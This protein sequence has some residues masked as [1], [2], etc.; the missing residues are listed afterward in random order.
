[1]KRIILSLVSVL[2]IFNTAHSQIWEY[3]LAEGFSSTVRDKVMTQDGGLVLCGDYCAGSF[4]TEFTYNAFVMKLSA[5]GQVEW[6]NLYFVS[7][8]ENVANGIDE[9]A[10]GELLVSLSR[11]DTTFLRKL[12]SDGNLIWEVMDP[13]HS[14]PR[15]VAVADNNTIYW[16]R[17]GFSE[18]DVMT[19]KYDNDGNLIWETDQFAGEIIKTYGP[20][21]IQCTGPEIWY[22]IDPAT[23][24]IIESLPVMIE[25]DPDHQSRIQDMYIH[26]SLGPIILG[27]LDIQ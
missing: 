12:S 16:S 20:D 26:E 23:G 7:D 21:S 9:N 14:K 10:A 8:D 27:G 1:M 17:R 2:F 13:N 18:L 11:N 25:T 22:E 15:D 4:I 24:N 19:S 5:N 3:I 6:N